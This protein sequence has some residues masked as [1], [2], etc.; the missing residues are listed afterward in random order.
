[1]SYKYA[2]VGAGRQ[3]VAAAYDLATLGDAASVLMV[4]ANLDAATAAATT[5]NGL[6]GR[7]IVRAAR[8]DATD[9]AA[10]RA[11]LGGTDAIL[12]AAH[13]NVNLGLT[14]VAVSL[15]A[16]LCDLGGHTG[17][18]RQQ[19]AFD[20]EAKQ[21]GVTIAPDCGM[22][23]GLNVS[24]GAY[25]MEQL[26]RTREVLIWDGGLPQDP[27]PPWNYVSTFAMSGLTNEYAGSAY[28]LRH[29]E[30]TEVPCFADREE[31]EFAPPVGRLEAFVTSGGLST[32]PWTW[33]GTLERLENKTLR[34]LGHCAA[35]TAFDQLGLLGLDPIDAAGTT[36]VPR[37]VL[38]ALLEPRIG[39]RGAVVRD[40]CI[41]RVK[42]I[43]DRG[44]QP[45][46]VTVELIDRY[47]ERTGFTAMQRL[48]GWH[49]AIVLGLAARGQLPR[50]VRSVESIAGSLIVAEGKKRGWQFTE[51]VRATGAKR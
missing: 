36:I 4:D 26:D 49:A 39:A 40:I 44:G 46:E 22:G 13:Y 50:G 45:T 18:V 38:H 31:L 43:G 20:A 47:D 37:D 10:L 17:V 9:L 25:V 28:F 34:Y 23:P 3:G 32:S 8:C 41:M 2:V 42:G 35:F 11:V 30:V 21:A 1:M 27:H 6:I 24:L 33:K 29:G 51:S 14:E 48:T 5:L 15:K 12:S 19:H 16:H 7:P